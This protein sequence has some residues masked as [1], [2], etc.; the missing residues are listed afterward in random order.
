MNG[1][2]ALGGVRVRVRGARG[3]NASQDFEKL[4]SLDQ[5]RFCQIKLASIGF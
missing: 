4:A 2:M 3:V 1:G 5:V